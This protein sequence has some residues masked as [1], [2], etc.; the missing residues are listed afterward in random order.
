MSA[1]RESKLSLIKEEDWRLRVFD[2]LS[3]PTL[4]LKPDK[5]VLTANRVFLEKYRIPLEKLVGK[6]C[7][8][9]FY[10]T[11][12]C[13]HSTCPF[14]KVIKERKG[15]SILRRNFTRTGKRTWED[16]VFSPILN[17]A[18][19]VAYVMESIRDV[20]HVKMLEVTLKKTQLFFEKVIQ[21]SAMAIVAAD[22]YAN[23]LLMNPSAE[24]LFG[25]AAEDAIHH[26]TADQLYPP[27]V[28][29]DIMQYMRGEN[30][31]GPG[32][33]AS[34][35]INILN[36]GGAEIPV[37]LTGS[38]IYEDGEEVATMG[39]YRD[40]REQIAVEK[41]LAEARAQLTQSEK[42]ASMGQLAAGVAH[43][44]NNPLTS[45]LFD[46]NLVRD[47]LQ[48]EDPNRENLNLIMQD[49][50][51]C[52]EI[53]KSLLAYSRQTSPMKG[54]VQINDLLEQSL[55]LIRDQKLFANIRIVKELS[56]E[57][58]LIRVDKNQI[59]QVVINL[60]LNAI[61]AM[62]GKG[63][64]S[65]RTYRDKRQ[66]KVYLEV[67]DTGCGIPEKNLSKVFDPFFTTKAVGKGTGMGLSTAYGNVIENKGN[68]CVKSSS[69]QG[70]T[71]LME[72]PL[73]QPSDEYPTV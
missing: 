39:I 33:L 60:V 10:G 36:A 29:Q 17:E 27:G 6:T 24:D 35:R 71:F 44:L 63:T 30:H 2:S 42:M 38:I 57:M 62:D 58:M 72:F 68:I 56:D 52:R 18:G 45:I 50:Y 69:P 32:K 61:D 49:V 54:V 19:E 25:Y 67:S 4:I 26:L 64:L 55:L 47:S 11:Q 37:E 43:E 16:R 48:E 40:L 13:P 22:R 53:V 14:H 7:H 1:Q 46:A 41:R 12:K 3:F 20:T 73:Y 59:S 9:V 21:S 70:T 23:I 34:R 66:Q 51:R 15:Q 8:E 65:F 5:V 31:G 28:A